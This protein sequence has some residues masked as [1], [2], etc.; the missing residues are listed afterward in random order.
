VPPG[1]WVRA[2]PLAVGLDGTGKYLHWGVIQLSLA[3]L[4]VVAIIVVLF[5]LAVLLPFPGRSSDEDEHQQR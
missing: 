4:V 1:S 3:N 2:G 5:V